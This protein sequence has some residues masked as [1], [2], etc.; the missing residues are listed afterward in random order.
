MNAHVLC[1]EDDPDIVRA[2]EM[3]LHRADIA[4]TS[5]ADGR[6]GLRCFHN[7]HPDAVL[8]DVGLPKL[9]GWEVLARI[10]D[11]SDVPVLLLTARGQL[12]EKVRGLQDGAD[13]YLTKPFANA[14]LL[15]RVRALLRRRRSGVPDPE[16]YD[17]GQVELSFAAHQV[18][19]NDKP[20]ELTPGEVRLLGA[21]VR[22][23]GQALSADQLR[24][25]AWS[26]PQRTERPAPGTA[27]LAG[28]M[29]ELSRKLGRACAS[30]SPIEALPG[31]G[32]R[33]V[34]PAR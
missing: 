13:D 12:S 8:L 20:L 4:V 18:R 28:A 21:L 7:E 11:A 26:D 17:D 5:A 24:D 25:E 27:K 2:V 34:R 1:I 30:G 15:A 9:D 29:A 32:Y 31:S 3:V 22:H 19:V 33:Y 14:V 6:E 23:A 10:R 16:V